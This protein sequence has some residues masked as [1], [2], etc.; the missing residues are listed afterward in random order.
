MLFFARVLCAGT[1]TVQA[2]WSYWNDWGV[3][4][5]IIC[6]H[7]MFFI[8]VWTH[9][10]VLAPRGPHSRNSH[11]QTNTALNSFQWVLPQ[12]CCPANNLFWAQPFPA[13][14]YVSHQ[15]CAS[16]H[17][18]EYYVSCSNVLTLMITLALSR[19]AIP[20]LGCTRLVLWH[21]FTIHSVNVNGC[22][23]IWLLSRVL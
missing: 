14:H 19:I 6:I 23:Y 8:S 13:L 16:A 12:G 3:F 22:I 17:S 2:Q 9:L 15:I 1:I 4:F 11:C 5:I 21:F 18:R 10:T 7:F 20:K